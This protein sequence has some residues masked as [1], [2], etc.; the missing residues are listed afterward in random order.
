MIRWV[1]MIGCTATQKAVFESNV[2]HFPRATKQFQ[3]RS[4]V[5]WAE[6]IKSTIRGNTS[7]VSV[8][9]SS[10]LS[11]TLMFFFFVKKSL[12]SRIAS[13]VKQWPNNKFSHYT[14]AA[15]S[16]SLISNCASKYRIKS[17]Y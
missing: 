8:V 17:D 14:S 15:A 1:K 2:D 4:C 16:R 12:T 3:R 6:L 5:Q 10:L 7:R 13:Q 9:H 11:I